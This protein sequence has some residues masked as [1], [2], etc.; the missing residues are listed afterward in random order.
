MNLNNN[1]GSMLLG[2]FLIGLTVMALITI[3]YRMTSDTTNS[4]KKRREN[5]SAFN[6]AEA[7]KEF[8]L[9]ELRSGKKVPFPDSTITFYT[10]NPFSGGYYS[11]TCYGDENLDTITLTS[12]GVRGNQS[13]T[14]EAK[15]LIKYNDF[16]VSASIDAAVTT[17]SDVTASGNITIDGR[18]HDINGNMIGT[19]TKAIKSCDDITQIGN[20]KIG[21]DGD[22]PAKDVTDPVIEEYITSADYPETPEQLLGL[23]EGALNQFKTSTLPSMP[24]SGIVYYV[25]PYDT[26]NVPNMLGSQGIFIV[27]NDSRTAKMMNI[28]GD[29]TGLIISDQIHHINAGAKIIGAVYTLSEESGTN[30]FGNGDADI[31]YSSSVIDALSNVTISVADT[32]YEILSWRQIN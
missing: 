22:E 24:F 10:K 14:L 17:R 18:D 4:V 29:F 15:C 20:S 28:D 21:G 27:H 7:G 19:G 23:P 31:L 9:A 8:A 25:P 2:V 6:I 16:T 11:V 30:A 26:F 1:R 13:A 12:I 32:E 5:I 3:T